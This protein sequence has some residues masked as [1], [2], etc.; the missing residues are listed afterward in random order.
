MKMVRTRSKK[1]IMATTTISEILTVHEAADDLN[2]T[3]HRV[4]EFIRDGRLEAVKRG[5][6][7]FI[8]RDSLKRFKKTERKVGRPKSEEN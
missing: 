5:T 7:Y 8:L 2:L 6:F 1:V 4:R 3:P